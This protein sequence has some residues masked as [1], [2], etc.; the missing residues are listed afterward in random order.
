MRVATLEEVE[1]IVNG[2]QK[3]K[4][5]CLD[6]F[7]TEFYQTAWKFMGREI[8]E[9]VEESHRNQKVCPCLNS[10]FIV[11][12]PKTSK[13]KDPQG[14]HPISLCNVIYKIIATVIVKLI[15]SLLSNIISLEQRG[16]V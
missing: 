8:L 10:T 12:V 16:F 7:T 11:L 14:F 2:M 1:E 15:K 6:G 13:S 3:N 5:P 4:A 9:V